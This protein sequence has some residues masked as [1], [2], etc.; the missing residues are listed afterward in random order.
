MMDC[1][2]FLTND[3]WYVEKSIEKD[4]DIET[5]YEL[6]EKAPA[7]AKKSFEEWQKTLKEAEKKGYD[8]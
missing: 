2:Y 7:E 8:L 6:T 4:G 3:E 1:P 5:V